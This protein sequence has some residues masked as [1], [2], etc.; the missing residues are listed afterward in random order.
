MLDLTPPEQLPVQ[1]VVPESP[2]AFLTALL[3]KPENISWS[4]E[5]K[6][7]ERQRM[8][9]YMFLAVTA[10]TGGL[11]SWWQSSWLTLIVVFLGIIAWELHNRLPSGH[12]I[13]IDDKG[14]SVD[15]Y[16]HRYQHLHSYDIHNMP[17]GSIHLSIMTSRWHLPQMHL[18]L[19]DQ[20]HQQVDAL[21]SR[22][23]LRDEH[24]IPLLDYLIKK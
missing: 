23:L 5:H 12:R 20:D 6:Q 3:T 22:Y 13:D 15:G 14:V 24:K 18:P 11:V 9:E 7:T 19:G 10:L 16:R 2:A 21:L 8:R 4:F 17:D 1:E